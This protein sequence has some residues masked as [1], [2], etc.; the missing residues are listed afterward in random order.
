MSRQVKELHSTSLWLI[1][2][3]RFFHKKTKSDS[4]G[5][6]DQQSER[7]EM[8]SE[9]V[10]SQMLEEVMDDLNLPLSSRETI[11]Y[12]SSEQQ[13][14]MVSSHR[15][16]SMRPG[17]DDIVSPKP[18]LQTIKQTLQ[19]GDSKSQEERTQALHE[20]AIN[21]R[22]RPMRYVLQFI[23]GH[24]LRLLLDLIAAMDYREKQ[25]VEHLNA[26]KCIAALMNN[27]HGLKCVLSHPHSIS[28]VTQSLHTSDIP[29]KI[30]V[31]ETIGAVC[32]IPN[33]H[34]QVLDALD[35]FKVFAGE[36]TR[37]QTL[38]AELSRDTKLSNVDVDAKTAALSLI[39]ALICA[40]PGRT[41]VHFRMHMRH[42]FLL[43]GID[44]VIDTLKRYEN[45]ALEK[46]IRI[47][48]DVFMDD[49]DQ[50]GS[51]Y[52]VEEI[53]SSNGIEMVDVLKKRLSTSAGY[54]YVL[55]VLHH[56]TIMPSDGK[57][58]EHRLKLL[59]NIA[60]QICI[61]D[62]EGNDPDVHPI[63]IDLKKAIGHLSCHADV[64]AAKRER[65]K[66]I[67]KKEDY[68]AR[69]KKAEETYKNE[70]LDKQA[71]KKSL[72]KKIEKIKRDLTETLEQLS[73]VTNE[74]TL[75]RAKLNELEKILKEGVPSGA[76]AAKIVVEGDSLSHLPPT[77]PRQTYVPPP[78][79]LP[80]QASI[81]PPPPMP[82]QV[83]MPPP[84]PPM[85]GQAEIPPPPPP[86]PGQVGMPPPPPSILGA[87]PIGSAIQS[88]SL[89][90]RNTPKPKIPMK[91]FNW[92]KLP[93]PKLKDT[94]WPEL[95]EENAF[96]Y[97]DQNE[98]ELHF[99]THQKTTSAKEELDEPIRKQ[100]VN[101]VDGRRAQNCTIALKKL[102]MSNHEIRHAILSLDEEC[103]MSNDILEQL[104]KYVPTSEEISMLGELV[105][106]ID[107]FGAADRFIWEMSQ[108]PRYEQRLNAIFFKRKINERMGFIEPQIACVMQACKE[109]ETS[110]AFH[111]LL[112]LVLALG[113]Y[114]NKG[115]RGGAYGFKLSS[116][117]RAVDTKSTINRDFTMLHFIFDIIDKNDKCMEL[118]TVADSIAAVRSACKV[119]LVEVR[120]EITT[121]KK[122]FTQ[123]EGELRWH[124]SLKVPI[125][126]D[127][128]V[129]TIEEFVK[130]E[131]PKL[132]ELEIHHEEMTKK[133]DSCVKK[134]DPNPPKNLEPAEFFGN[135]EQFLDSVWR[136][137]RDTEA[138][139]KREADKANRAHERELAKSIQKRAEKLEPQDQPEL[140]D[141][142][143]SL[144]SGEFAGATP[145][146]NP[147]AKTRGR[148]NP[149]RRQ[150][151]QIENVKTKIHPDITHVGEAEA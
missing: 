8:P 99:S 105:A 106:Q 56:M 32:L 18:L 66:A 97:L 126:G 95:N 65:N 102:K 124:S 77:L 110:S 19:S 10:L 55:S 96:K 121:L 107:L 48:D 53:D 6:S 41:S 67:E 9:E 28:V 38:V 93:V 108:I 14:D 4:H 25:T 21:M 128:F 51:L 87:F 129:D 59:S 49:M 61:Q 81:P 130:Q 131:K 82:G 74:N 71:V 3:P 92:V 151:A 12:M 137:R 2:M 142:I 119:C 104:M 112:E 31:L 34:R 64:I 85:L 42:E 141:L 120:K 78:P 50:I 122:G 35:R 69:C 147:M 111:Q 146:S 11:K 117:L 100:E 15:E 52:G 132:I 134:F 46:H 54:E 138:I 16:T 62:E 33:G 88:F 113:N 149:R 70:V 115:G 47:F 90:P 26:V 125:D 150:T 79:P 148:A 136:A 60:Q 83:G 80:G 58:T 1:T 63:K 84:P 75:L 114:L 37:F 5:D 139:Q 72:G 20:L 45:D 116:L 39:N 29:T 94:I 135:L 27:A 86:M 133:F 103:C 23:E 24:G 98:I 57:T 123:L 36:R 143:S 144:K 76:D 68:K 89:P 73:S 13:W 118:R 7:D 127:M 101:V 22:S 140:D 40:G 43:L 91:S 145:S 17:G 44:P 30:K 109:I